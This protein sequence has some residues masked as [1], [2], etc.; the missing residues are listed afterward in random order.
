MNGQIPDAMLLCYPAVNL[1]TNRFTPSLFLC[2]L[3]IKAFED[4]IVPF[5]YLKVISKL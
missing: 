1:D 3:L 5:I 2:I 4:V